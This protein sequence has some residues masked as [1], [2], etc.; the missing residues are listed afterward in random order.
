VCVLRFAFCV[1]LVVVM[2]HH[3]IECVLCVHLCRTKDVSKKS[4]C[5]TDGRKALVSTS[6]L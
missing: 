3:I 1:L 6:S 4:I 5:A 2:T